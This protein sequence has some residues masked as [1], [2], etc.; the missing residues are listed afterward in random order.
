MSVCCFVALVFVVVFQK[1]LSNKIKC[2]S[3]KTRQDLTQ[4]RLVGEKRGAFQHCLTRSCNLATSWLN[5]LVQRTKGRI[6]KPFWGTKTLEGNTCVLKTTLQSS[7]KCPFGDLIWFYKIC[8]WPAS[9][10]LQGHFE[11]V[12]IDWVTKMILQHHLISC[13]SDCGYPL[14]PPQEIRDDNG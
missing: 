10:S 13:K 12:G 4:G 8:K 5:L 14:P 6:G 2:S 9:E 3:K 1:T 7:S 11:E